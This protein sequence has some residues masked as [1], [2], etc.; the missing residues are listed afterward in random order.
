M[1]P[2]GVF[3]GHETD[4]VFM[5]RGSVTVTTYGSYYIRLSNASGTRHLLDQITPAM[6]DDNTKVTSHVSIG[7]RSMRMNTGQ[8]NKFDHDLV[9]HFKRHTYQHCSKC[10]RSSQKIN[11]TCHADCTA[12]ERRSGQ[13]ALFMKRI[14]HQNRNRAKDQDPNNPV[15]LRHRDMSA[16]YT[17]PL[18]SHRKSQPVRV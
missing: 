6:F 10:R 3:V 8:T 12:V 17:S 11:K 16:A 2:R 5:S 9:L 14:D 13:E 18:A 15:F 7:D 4:R 1:A